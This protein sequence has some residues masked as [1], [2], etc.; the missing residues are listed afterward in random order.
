MI[1]MGLVWVNLDTCIFVSRLPLD[2]DRQ[3][4]YWYINIYC[5]VV[6]IYIVMRCVLSV[7]VLSL[8]VVDWLPLKHK[9]VMSDPMKG[10]DLGLVAC[11][12][13]SKYSQQC[14]SFYCGWVN[15]QLSLLWSVQTYF[16][17][18]S[19]ARFLTLLCLI[20]ILAVLGLARYISYFSKFPA[21]SRVSW[22]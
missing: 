15:I 11:T 3:L 1:G 2:S 21:C 9:W 8:L 16:L 13:K 20:S 18:I 19:F 17:L 10:T 12:T 14:T 22:L 7:F 6:S 5:M 4:K